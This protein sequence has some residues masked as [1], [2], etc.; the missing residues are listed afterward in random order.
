MKDSFDAKVMLPIIYNAVLEGC[1]HNE[2]AKRLDVSRDTWHRWRLEKTDISDTLQAAKTE[3]LVN[4][5]V[6]ARY[7]LRKVVSGYDYTEK[8]QE[9]SYETVEDENGDKKRVKTLVGE[10]VM[11]KH[12]EPQ[13][14]AITYVLNNRNPVDFPNAQK[15]DTVINVNP[16]QEGSGSIG[17]LSEKFVEVLDSVKQAYLNERDKASQAE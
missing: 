4:L 5:E 2:I 1:N 9:Y 16:V 6:E 10:R 11:V 8:V 12:R 13:T 3:F 17:Q 15:A 7:S 14:A